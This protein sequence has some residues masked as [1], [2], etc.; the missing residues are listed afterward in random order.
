MSH[1]GELIQTYQDK[2]GVSDRALGLRVD[3]SATLIGKWKKGR[4]AE[5]PSVERVHKL[6]DH[7]GLNRGVVLDAFLRDLKYLPEERDGDDR[8]TAPT[9]VTPLSEPASKVAGDDL[10]G[11]PSVAHKPPKKG[12]S[13]D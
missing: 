1:I 12:P 2:H 7:I 8:D 13:K 5:V 3:V 10:T 9:N 11:L 4:F 6:A